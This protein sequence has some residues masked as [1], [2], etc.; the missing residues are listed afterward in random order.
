[1]WFAHLFGAK[2][3]SIADSVRNMF[4][5]KQEGSGTVLT[6]RATGRQFGAGTFSTPKLGGLRQQASQLPVSGAACGSNTSLH[7]AVG[8]VAD[9]H[10]KADN[11]HATFQ[12][13]SQFNCLEVRRLRFEV[14]AML[15][16]VQAAA[17]AAA[18]TNCALWAL[19]L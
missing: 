16:S 2:E 15:D 13:A 18:L 4:E 1:M 11:R 12:V 5:C 9:L 6:V 3:P 7:I 19:S 10:A 8:D 17:C 14:L